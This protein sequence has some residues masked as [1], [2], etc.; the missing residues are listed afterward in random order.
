[1]INGSRVQSARLG[2]FIFSD[3][4]VKIT[5]QQSH[6]EDEDHISDLGIVPV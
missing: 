1:M 6:T 4:Y 3:S 2:T 5:A